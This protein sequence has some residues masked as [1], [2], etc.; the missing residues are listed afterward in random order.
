MADTVIPQEPRPQCWRCGADG[1]Y[2]DIVPFHILVCGRFGLAYK[3]L[4]IVA[5]V[6]GAR[7]VEHP[8]AGSQGE[9]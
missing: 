7:N 1:V 2:S 6:Q 3:S 8:G 4:M 9:Q 5:Q